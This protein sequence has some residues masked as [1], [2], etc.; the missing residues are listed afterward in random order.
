MGIS[1]TADNHA[2]PHEQPLLECITDSLEKIIYLKGKFIL[3]TYKLQF[4]HPYA[5]ICHRRNKI[6][7][8]VQAAF[9][10]MTFLF[11]GRE[12]L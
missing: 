1:Y 2:A 12:A 11:Y 8:I 4:T 9:P 3:K 5:F 10:N 7:Q 6:L